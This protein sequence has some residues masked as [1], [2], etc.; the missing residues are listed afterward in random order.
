[1]HQLYERVD[2]ATWDDALGRFEAARTADSA[3]DQAFWMPAYR[4]QEASGK[5]ISSA[6]DA[7]MERLQGARLE[8]EEELVMTP[9]PRM[10]AIIAKIELSRKRWE[11]FTGWADTWWDAVLCD[12]RRLGGEG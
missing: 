8:A 7:E 4:E 12:L 3:Y 11:D 1:M 9:A 5:H 2:A 6:V 10:R